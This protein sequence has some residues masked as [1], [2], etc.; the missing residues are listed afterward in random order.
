MNKLENPNL[1]NRRDYLR[2]NVLPRLQEMQRDLFDNE[3]LTFDL[4][5][6]ACGLF[7][8]AFSSY[9]LNRKVLDSIYLNFS[10][11]DSND[12]FESEYEKLTEFIKKYSA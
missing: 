2:G 8:S 6:G 11:C 4:S 10:V 7:V 5:V 12:Q 9:I 3:H 1:K